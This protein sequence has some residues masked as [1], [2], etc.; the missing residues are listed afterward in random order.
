MRVNLTKHL[1]RKKLI[2][3]RTALPPDHA[4]RAAQSLKQH[5]RDYL[6]DVAGAVVAC[7]MPFRGEI[8]PIPVAEMIMENKA[9]IAMPS[10]DKNFKHMIF[11][12]WS[13]GDRT[14]RNV[15]GIEEPAPE[16]ETL[17]PN[18]LLLPLVGFD[19]VGFRLGYGGGYYDRALARLRTM[20]VKLRV[21]GLAYALQQVASLPYEAHDARLDAVVTER[22][23]IEF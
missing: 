10:V 20:P 19:E 16:A 13:P 2:A 1:L 6:G 22:G 4:R 17:V 23:V 7:Y 9:V 5:V 18:I 3:D 12:K 11:K 21:V 14:V 8:N 15:Y